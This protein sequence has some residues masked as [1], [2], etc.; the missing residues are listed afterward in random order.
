MIASTAPVA[1]VEVGAR[2]VPGGSR[3]RVSV[4][5]GRNLSGLAGLA[6]AVSDPEGPLYGH[7]LSSAQVQARFGATTAQQ[8]AV[9]AWLRD[10][11]LTVTQ[12]DAFTVTATGT[13]AR[14]QAALGGT[15][16]RWTQW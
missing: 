12:V 7:F 8:Q 9:A 2:A 1:G 3:V 15:R 4:F 13:A 11:G 6:E 14:A 5:T 10:S 16:M